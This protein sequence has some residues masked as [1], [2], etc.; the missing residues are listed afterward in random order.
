MHVCVH[1]WVY[2]GACIR[3]CA[4][5]CFLGGAQGASGVGERKQWGVGMAGPLASSLLGG[6]RTGALWPRTWPLPVAEGS[7]LDCHVPPR[8]DVNS[9][10]LGKKEGE[11]CLAFCVA[12]RP[13][14][15]VRWPG[16]AL[17]A[18]TH[19][20]R[21][22]GQAIASL[23]ASVSPLRSTPLLCSGT[24]AGDQW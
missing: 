8:D 5:G 15:V 23:S 7:V 1:R 22:L 4:C 24:G 18:G 17:D 11:S 10:P 9:E 16:F 13:S 14:L 19:E 2:T 21:D 20:S 6:P 3:V 12:E